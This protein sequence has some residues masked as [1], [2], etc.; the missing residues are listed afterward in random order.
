MEK[1]VV[2]PKFETE[3]EFVAWLDSLKEEDFVLEVVPPMEEVDDLRVDGKD[4][5]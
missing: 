5:E 4:G 3:E 2:M 1:F